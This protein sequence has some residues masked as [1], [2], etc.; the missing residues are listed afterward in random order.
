MHSMSNQFYNYISE[1]LLNYFNEVS[2]SPGDRFYLQLDKQEEVEN[3]VN[4]LKLHKDGDFIYQHDYGNPYHSFYININDIRLVLAYTSSFVRP[5]FLVTLRNLVGEQLDQWERTALLSIVTEQLDSIQGGSSDLQKEGMPLH[6]NYLSEK[7]INEIE[8]SDMSKTDQIILLDKIDQIIEERSFQHITFFEFEEV[9]SVL[10]KGYIEQD[11]YVKF[12]LFKDED[13][14]TY[15]GR[16]L[17]ER[18]QTNRGL[19][20]FVKKVHDFGSPEEELEQMFSPQGVNK[21]KTEDWNKLSFSEVY[22]FHEDFNKQNKKTKIVLKEITVKNGLAHWDRPQSET[23]AGKRKRHIIVFNPNNL[24]QIE[25]QASFNI[26]GGVKSLSDQFLT[27]HGKEHTLVKV[28]NTNLHIT[29]KV[30]KGKCVFTKISYKHDKKASLGAEF[31]ISVLPIEAIFMDQMKT[32]YL[33]NPKNEVIEIQYHGDEISL[34]DGGQKKKIEISD[35][36]TLINYE[37]GD[38]LILQLLPDAFTD[39]EE[40]LINLNIV[41]SH[42]S[43]IALLFKNELPESTPISGM[44][45][46]KLKRENNKSFKWYG[47]RLVFG[48]REFYIHSEYKHYFEWEKQWIENSIRY[49]ELSSEELLEHDIEL[50]DNLREA[51][52]RFLNVFSISEDIPSLRNYDRELTLR[53]EDYVKAY[54]DEIKTFTEDQEAGKR[55]RDLFK[56][57]T[58]YASNCIY[59]TPFHPLVVA[60]QLMINKHL[61][62]EE[63]DN[64]IINRLS[65][66]GLIPFIYIDVGDGEQLYKPDSQQSVPEWIIFKPV[67]QIN[68][69]DANQYM[70]KVIEEKI[71][72]FEDHFKYLFIEQ[73]NAPLLINVIN[74]SNDLEVIKGIIHWML[75][76]IKKKGLEGLKSVEVTLYNNGRSESYFDIFSRVK[77]MESFE[78]IFHLN[79]RNIKGY[80]GNDLLRIIRDK[81]KYF[82]QNMNGEY[83]YSHISFYK[84]Q[85]QESIA[86]QSTSDMMTGITLDGLYTSIPSMK[87]NEN[88]RSG[89]GIKPYSLDQTNLLIKTAYYLNELSANLRNNGN[90]TYRKDVAIVSRTTNADESILEKIYKASYWVTFIDPNFD[91]EFFNDYSKNLIVIHYS[92]QYSSSSRYDAITVT[93]KSQQYFAAIKEFLKEKGVDGSE[94]NV[95]NTIKA[96]NTFNGEWLLRIIG[97][98]GHYPREKLSII[99]A[100]KFSL[101]YFDHKNILWVPISLEEILRV[102]GAVNLNKSDGIFTAKNLGVTGAHSDDL[103]LIGLEK[104]EDQLYLH[105]YPIEVKIGFNNS[106]VL[107]KAK[108]QI[109]KTKALIID[110]LTSED[111]RRFT[112]KF[113]RNFFVQL[114]IA[115]AKKILQSSFWPEK[116]Y[117]LSDSIIEKLLTD[118]FTI[119]DHLND[120]IGE[121][122]ILSFKNDAFYRSSTQEEGIT[123]L[124]LPESD[125]YFGLVQSISEMHHWIQNKENDF[126]KENLL[127][128]RYK[129]NGSFEKEKVEVIPVTG[130]I[131]ES[132]AVRSEVSNDTK[133]ND[134]K[135]QNNDS[136]EEERTEITLEKIKMDSLE[137]QGSDKKVASVEYRLLIGTAEN[138]NKEIYWE[139]GHNEL[140][141]RHLLISGKSGQGKTYFMQCLLLEKSKLGIPSIVIDYTEGFLPNQL[142]PEFIQFLGDKLIQ[143]IVFNEQF[144]I[145]PF[146]KNVRDIGGLKLPESDTD[147]AERIK[148]VFSAVYKSLG[149]QQQNAIYEAVLRGLSKYGDQMNLIRLK[150]SLEEDNSNYAKTALSQIRPLIDRNPFSHE[151]T[152]D[153]RSIVNSDGQVFVIQLTGYPR[154]VQLIITEFILWDLWNYSIRFGSKNIPIP[155]IMDEAQNLDH[156]E[157]SPSARILTEGRK[158]GWSAWYATQFLKSQLDAD[159]LARLQNATQK[160]YFSPPEQEISNIASSFSNDPSQRKVWE[161]KL[162]ELKKGQCIV[163]GPIK[164]DN[165]ELSKPIVT[166]VDITPLSK[167]IG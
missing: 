50:S 86:I 87:S 124:N 41:D 14:G 88:Y 92:D 83:R 48:N 152:I 30:D 114:F 33:V 3:L 1:L 109:K 71:T 121:G 126:V 156:T 80:D 8:K 40:L 85:A 36:N 21:L 104:Q 81:L 37:E 12:G 111:D 76:K 52:S 62:N 61:S 119:S 25:L 144:P 56:L 74:I 128:N 55:G 77:S 153:W 66:E 6:P 136:K 139:Y 72:Q 23:A 93:D 135:E 22:R 44:R 43:K 102:A 112:S 134:Q 18:L 141:N 35:H 162:A 118:Q 7:L 133:E 42:S 106:N 53:A 99:S 148:S 82:K 160:I 150:E 117:C 65:P 164:L 27:V 73:S 17:K 142:E 158:F 110:S 122:A 28:G 149:I 26:F 127:S 116:D 68:V 75:E 2:I 84:M 130:V 161:T 49:A 146:R 129:V 166:V 67:N 103:L 63:V 59:F 64:S 120:I 107:E 105:F 167:R 9:C 29:I 157:K 31:F 79:L 143:K 154:E 69:S 151:N 46:W 34:G 58:I 19:Y 101:S 131:T 123:I 60:Y 15:T 95:K 108:T 90:D 11:D 10:F 98:S 47:N 125:G 100:I 145:N 115:N 165:G 159:E 132:Y 91:L 39:D 89:F 96:F 97:G 54:I 138:S 113:Y 16:E 140:A 20:E 163:H 13:L 70:A 78:E 24:E 94:E 51:Y 45:I 137:D 155:V 147:V 57:G 38:Q 4:A 32:R 5:D